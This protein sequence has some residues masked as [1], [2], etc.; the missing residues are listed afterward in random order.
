MA[1]LKARGLDSA[2]RVGEKLTVEDG[3]E[4]AVESALGQLI[5]GVLVD[6][7]ERLVEALADLGEGRIA[8]V[9]DEGGDVPFAP[10]SLAAKVSGPLAVRRLLARLHAAEDLAEARGLMPR[11][12]EGDSIITRSGERLG[13]G[14]VRVS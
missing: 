14:W 11:L 2:A 13:E 9:S 6:A 10:T 5:E 12:G 7:P 8:L 1:W 4:N 3:W